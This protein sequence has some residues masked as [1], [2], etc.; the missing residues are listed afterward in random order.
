MSTTHARI[1]IYPV[2]AGGPT[3]A[4]ALALLLAGCTPAGAPAV[5]AD[6]EVEV[7]PDLEAVFDSAGIDG[8]FVLYDPAEGRLTVAKRLRAETRF[9]P[10]STYKLPHALIALETGA[11]A[12]VDEVVPY[13][14][15]PQ[16]FAAWE[17]DMSVRQA[18]PAS[19]VPVFQEVARRVG[20][21]RMQGWLD[22]LEYGNRDIGTV[23]DRFW[24]DGPLEISAIEQARFLAELA[25]GT[26]PAG[27]EAQAAVREVALLEA[28]EGHTLY[29]KTGW[30]FDVSPQVGWW[31]GWV[32]GE[33]GA[34][35][36]FALNLEMRSAD[37]APRRIE[38]GRELLRRL[39]TLPAQP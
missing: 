34:I 10:A 30:A 24:L 22:R 8:T 28:G 25:A 1:A 27:A 16:P 2:S 37:D 26:L 31:V 21:E 29:G 23:Q 20:P 6:P 9:V 14:G 19:S 12:D 4:I 17:R 11:V 3:P 38:L 13:G 33:D 32:E 5:S 36:A 7:R 39:G 35:H 18:V 15:Q